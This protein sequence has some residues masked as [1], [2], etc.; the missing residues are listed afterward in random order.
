VVG[1]VAVGHSKKRTTYTISFATPLN[2]SS[3]NNASLYRVLQGVTKVVKKHKQTVFT[4]SLKIQSVAYNP[5]NSSVTI[6]LA[7]PFKE[8]AQ[9]TIEPGLEAADG[10]SSTTTITKLVP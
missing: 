2:A 6:T 9:V 4:K 7:K 5:G 1:N 3:A 10:A 8:A